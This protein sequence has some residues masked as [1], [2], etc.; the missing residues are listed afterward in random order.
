MCG[1]SHTVTDPE[2]PRSF[3]GINSAIYPKTLSKYTNTNRTAIWICKLNQYVRPWPHIKTFALHLC[4]TCTKLIVVLLSVPFPQCYPNPRWATRPPLQVWSRPTAPACPV[5]RQR[6]C[7]TW[8]EI[9]APWAPRW[10]RCSRRP[11][12]PL[13]SSVRWLWSQGC[14]KTCPSSAWCTTEA[15]SR[16]SLFPWTLKVSWWRWSV[17]C[18]I[19]S[20]FVQAS[21]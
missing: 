4:Y 16:P 11:T 2:A 21:T 8:S 17:S 14:W 5:P 12:G 19:A 3:P 10:P 6:S 18:G 13:W 7:G 9:T 20:S 15:W 1:N